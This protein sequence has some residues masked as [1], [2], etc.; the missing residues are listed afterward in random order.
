MTVEVSALIP[1][2]L[3]VLWLFFSYLFY[4][5]N[6]GLT[7]GI[8]EEALQKAADIRITGADYDTGKI[9][10]AKLNQNLII[11]NI[12]SSNKNGDTMAQKE[13]KEKKEE[14]EEKIEISVDD[15]EGQI[16][17]LRQLIQKKK[18]E[19]TKEDYKK[20]KRCLQNIER[21]FEK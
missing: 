15:F 12:I 5:M 17:R 14:R 18:I 8:M 16:T 21:L 9:S 1:I 6:C 20:Y 4:F 11:G 2:V 19:L 13:I 7:Q 10:Y 3:M